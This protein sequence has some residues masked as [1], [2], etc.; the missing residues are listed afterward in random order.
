MC[1]ADDTGE[2]HEY[3]QAHVSCLMMMIARVQI[4]QRNSL[5]DLCEGSSIVVRK[6]TLAFDTIP[7]AQIFYNN[8][9]FEQRHLVIGLRPN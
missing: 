4:G 3:I 7:C 1:S 5:K 6:F 2:C 9:E 8:Q